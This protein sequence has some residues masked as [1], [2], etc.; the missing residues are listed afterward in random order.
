LGQASL[1]V[2]D[3]IVAELEE[4]AELLVEEFVVVG[5]VVPEQRIGLDE[6]PAA[7]NNLGTAVGDEIQG[8]ELLE[9]P[10][11]V[12]RGQHGH[13]RAEPEVGGFPGDGRED[14]FR[15][16]ECEIVPMVLAQAHE[17]EP[18]LVRQLGEFDDLLQPLPG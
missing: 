5:G 16:G 6:R 10:H 13:R 2:Q 14:D 9:K 11:G 18:R 3:S 15:G 7:G 8:G 4:H 17:A 1:P 12:L